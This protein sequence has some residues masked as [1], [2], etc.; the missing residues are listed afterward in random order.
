[1]RALL[2]AAG[3]L[4]QPG[5]S[6]HEYDTLRL[7]LHEKLDDIVREKTKRGPG[8]RQDRLSD[9]SGLAPFASVTKVVRT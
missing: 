4:V 1:M 2:L 5:R 9:R 6:G 8:K 3:S 7:V